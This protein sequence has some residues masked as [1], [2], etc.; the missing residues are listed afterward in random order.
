M[1]IRV[2]AVLVS[3]AVLILQVPARAGQRSA[4]E[5]LFRVRIVVANVAEVKAS[6]ETSGRFYE[7]GLRRLEGELAL[8]LEP[9]R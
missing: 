9:K 1:K 4:D 2:L 7:A 3:L 8:A 5:P 6:L